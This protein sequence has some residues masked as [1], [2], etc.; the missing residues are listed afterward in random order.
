[1][2]N[3]EAFTHRETRTVQTTID[4]CVNDGWFALQHMDKDEQEPYLCEIACRNDSMAFE[5][6]INKTYNICKIACQKSGYN[7]QF[8]PDDFKTR[9][10]CLIAVKCSPFALE[11]LDEDKQCLE[12]CLVASNILP[13]CIHYV[14]D[15]KIKKYLLTII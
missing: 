14:R 11:F 3:R 8:V 6:V 1:M 15:K 7:I 12:V 10:M 2:I 4:M 5:H 9:E 13:D